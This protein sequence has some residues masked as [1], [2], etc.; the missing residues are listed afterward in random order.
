MP[1]SE[2]SETKVTFTGTAKADILKKWFDK[3]PEH[4]DISVRYEQG[5]VHDGV[6]NTIQ[7]IWTTSLDT[8]PGDGDG[9]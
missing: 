6:Q 5:V 7:A 9:N 3:V 4:A 2:T 1:I 8:V